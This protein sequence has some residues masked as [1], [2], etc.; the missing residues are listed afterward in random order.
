MTPAGRARQQPGTLLGL[1]GAALALLEALV[2]RSFEPLGIDGRALFHR[3]AE[4]GSLRG[5]LGLNEDA[6]E[7]LYARAYQYLRLG[8]VGR[9]EEIFRTLCA[10]DGRIPDHWLGFG[11]CLRAKGNFPQALEAFDKAAHLDPASA[12][13]HFHRLE[14]FL[15]DS[16]WKEAL[17]A[18]DR[19]DAAA[20]GDQKAH[21]NEAVTPFRKAI[22][23]H[24]A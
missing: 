11:I 13:P 4:T 19:F 23:I 12:A 9:A 3:L 2:T 10:L 8:Q 16:R 20:S 1:E 18:L 7:A 17:A 22:E 5:A 6:L 15:R 21:L 24:L 14:V